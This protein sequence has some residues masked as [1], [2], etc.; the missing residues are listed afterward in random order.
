MGTTVRA[1]TGLIWVAERAQG[2]QAS[3]QLKAF[4]FT[5]NV[6]QKEPNS[7]EYE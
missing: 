6:H 4:R 7:H 5:M 2:R 1:K 3:K